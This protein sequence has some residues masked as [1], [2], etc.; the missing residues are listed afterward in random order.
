MGVI[1]LK[2]WTYFLVKSLLRIFLWC[3]QTL[4]WKQKNR[5][6]LPQSLIWTQRIFLLYYQLFLC[7][8]RIYL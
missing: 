4:N 2:K 7:P 5:L 6:F 3:H 8:R 1:C